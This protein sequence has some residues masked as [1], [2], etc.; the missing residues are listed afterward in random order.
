DGCP[1]TARMT[2]SLGRGASLNFLHV[3]GVALFLQAAGHFY[4]SA[5]VASGFGLVIEFVLQ[6]AAT[7]E[8]TAVLMHHSS[9]KGPY[10]GVRG[11]RTRFAFTRLAALIRGPLGAW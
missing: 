5:L 1:A 10:L 3:N 7:K 6:I 2:G 4:A 11:G 8:I 9:H